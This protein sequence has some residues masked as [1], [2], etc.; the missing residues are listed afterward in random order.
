MSFWATPI[1]AASSAVAAPITAT[2]SS[3]AGA[4]V[5]SAWQRATMYTPAVT[6]VAAWI[7]AHALPAHEHEQEV[8]GQHQREHREHE[9]VEVQ[10]EPAERGIVRHVA[11]GVDVDQEADPGHDQRH[12]RR[13]R[14]QHERDV[15]PEVADPEP[16]P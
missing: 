1:V 10:E 13:Q 7:K 9:Q 11:G 6:M 2:T 12:H 8:V 3:V 14:I 15:G 16:R 5:N 4:S